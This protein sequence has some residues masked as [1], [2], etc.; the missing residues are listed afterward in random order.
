MEMG[1]EAEQQNK[2]GGP[3]GKEEGGEEAQAARLVSEVNGGR[4]VN[5]RESH[6]Q[7]KRRRWDPGRHGGGQESG[8]TRAEQRSSKLR[9]QHSRPHST[10]QCA[11]SAL[12]ATVNQ[13]Q[14]PHVL[15]LV[16]DRKPLAKLWYLPR[17]EAG[18][19]DTDEGTGTVICALWVPK[20]RRLQAA[21]CRAQ[22]ADS[23]PLSL[24][25]EHLQQVGR[26]RRGKNG[27][28]L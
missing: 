9:N 14:G 11:V 7:V 22:S 21:E 6:T 16:W 2:K 1:D 15:R 18:S 20:K 13:L 28:V 19:T 12:V 8:R 25:A 26:S 5:R 10:Q 23:T 4:V 17:L 3:E 27:E 24:P